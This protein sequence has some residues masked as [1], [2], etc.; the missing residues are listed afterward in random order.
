MIWYGTVCYAITI[1]MV[2]MLL[3]GMLRHC[4]A[5]NSPASTITNKTKLQTN[6]QINKRTNKQ[7]EPGCPPRAAHTI[8]CACSAGCLWSVRL[9]TCPLTCC[10]KNWFAGSGSAHDATCGRRRLGREGLQTRTY[11]NNVTKIR[12]RVGGKEL[13]NHLTGNLSKYQVLILSKSKQQTQTEAAIGEHTIEKT[14]EIIV[15]GSDHG[16]KAGLLSSR[17][18]SID[19][20]QQ[21]DRRPIETQKTN[22]SRS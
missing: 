7:T 19:Q 11:V 21:A 20:D 6:E 1:A 2:G 8:A 9:V 4:T 18:V 16:W 22:S 17:E 5:M 14:K 12:W 3:Y 13:G 15:A 10:W